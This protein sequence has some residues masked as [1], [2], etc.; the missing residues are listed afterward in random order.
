MAKTAVNVDTMYM[1]SLLSGDE[2]DSNIERLILAA[3]RLNSQHSNLET[4][5]RIHIS[6]SGAHD[7]GAINSI[8]WG[9]QNCRGENIEDTL[10]WDIADQ[11]VGQDVE[12]LWDDSGSEGF[13][14]IDLSAEPGK[15]VW[16]RV[17]Y[18]ETVIRNPTVRYY[19]IS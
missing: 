15:Q 11:F 6:F 1:E 9:D 3:M 14:Q 16:S 7:E 17:G 12:W 4:L 2:G 13:V 8:Y 10:F 5:G 18:Y 19:S